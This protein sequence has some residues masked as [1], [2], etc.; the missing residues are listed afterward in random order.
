MSDLMNW[1]YDHYIKP[2]LD[3][4]SQEFS[5]K[6]R[7]SLLQNEL[8]PSLN[9]ELNELLRAYTIRGFRLGLKTGAAVVRDLS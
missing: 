4:Q 2:T 7:L 6:M 3:T 8:P 9:K 5:D 1:L